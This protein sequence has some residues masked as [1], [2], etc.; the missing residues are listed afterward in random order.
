M[1]SELLILLETRVRELEAENQR[2]AKENKELLARVI[3]H[4]GQHGGCAPCAEYRYR[5]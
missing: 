2:L 1:V 5:P 4:V 3:Q